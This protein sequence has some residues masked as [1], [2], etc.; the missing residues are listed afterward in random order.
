MGGKADAQTLEDFL[1]LDLSELVEMK[2][3]TPGR[4]GQ[5]ATEAPANVTIMTHEMIQRCG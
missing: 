2:V 5:T 1:E 4:R 3:I